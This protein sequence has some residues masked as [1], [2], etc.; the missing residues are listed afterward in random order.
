MQD[1]KYEFGFYWM[2]KMKNIS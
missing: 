2:L 1:Y